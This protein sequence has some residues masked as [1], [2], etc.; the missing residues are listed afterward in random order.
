[1]LW[2]ESWIETLLARILKV[3][4]ARTLTLCNA[5]LLHSTTVIKRRLAYVNHFRHGEIWIINRHR[6]TSELNFPII[7]KKSYHPKQCKDWISY[8]QTKRYRRIIFVSSNH[9]V[10]LNTISL[11]EATPKMLS[12]LHLKTYRRC[13]MKMPDT[14]LQRTKRAGFHLPL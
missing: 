14:S 8:S 12:K 6:V 9:C 2:N 10:T 11:T 13:H 7:I 1:M 4:T 3:V 5:H